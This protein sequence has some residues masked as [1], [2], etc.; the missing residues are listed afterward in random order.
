MRCVVNME[1]GDCTFPTPV[2][3]CLSFKGDLRALI[4]LLDLISIF[5]EGGTRGRLKQSWNSECSNTGKSMSD[6][7]DRKIL[8]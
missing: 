1:S 5:S 8:S 4:S 3:L 2:F 7:D 6:R